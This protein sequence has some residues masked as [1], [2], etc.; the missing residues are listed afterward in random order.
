MTAGGER[1]E[2]PGED[3]GQDPERSRRG[4][5]VV[6][7]LAVTAVVV[8]AGSVLFGGGDETKLSSGVPIVPPLPGEEASVPAPA[9]VLAISAEGG[10]VAL[11]DSATGERR[12][13]LATHP[14]T[15]GAPVLSGVA[16][17]P[18]RRT[19]FYSLD[20][21]C[22]QGF[23][24]RVRTN[25]KSAPV[26]VARGISPAVSPDGKRLAYAVAGRRRPDGTPACFNAISVLELRNGKVR[27]WRYPEAEAYAG[28]LFTDASFT[29]LAWSPD[30]TRLAFTVSYEGD[31][32][33]VLD[34][35]RHRHLGEALEVVIPGG[36]GDSRHPAWHAPTGRL[37]L[38]NRAFECCFDDAYTG[39]PR[40]VLVDVAD[41]L[42]EDLFPPGLAPNGLDFDAG[43][44]HLLYVD[45]GSLFRRAEG[46]EAVLVAPGYTA[47][48]W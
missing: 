27:T 40:T 46:E 10:V 38:V 18:D 35:K 23:V 9:D 20:G 13:L 6:L 32:I 17:S 22:G 5:A 30:S 43:G 15:E 1:G 29:K 21:G 37:A 14:P 25:G 2:L 28:G 7:G 34:T 39:P 11:L 47:A 48:D 26:D 8:F 19:A 16:L 44:Q 36:G 24:R 33:S 41:R 12:A 42:A 3:E 4:P 31:S 45:E